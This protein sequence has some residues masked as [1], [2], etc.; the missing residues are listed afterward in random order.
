MFVT[1]RVALTH[2][3]EFLRLLDKN[4]NNFYINT[5]SGFRLVI[6]YESF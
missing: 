6:A 3:L 1:D 4:G 2:V 5:C